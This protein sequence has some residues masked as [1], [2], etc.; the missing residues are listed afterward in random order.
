MALTMAFQM[1]LSTPFQ[2]P[3]RGDGPP[4]A[5]G[6]AVKSRATTTTREAAMTTTLTLDKAGR[7]VIPKRIRERMHL[8]AGSRLRVEL[9]GDRLEIS[10]EPDEVQIERRGKRRVIVGWEGFDAAQAVQEAREEQLE[11]LAGKRREA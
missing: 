2:K 1:V 10:H 8:R 5:G 3:S 9:V 11:R 6:E 4:H 7:V